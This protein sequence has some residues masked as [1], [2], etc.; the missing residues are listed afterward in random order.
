MVGSGYFPL[1]AGE[2]RS[3]VLVGPC[4]LL[5]R[6]VV[7]GGGSVEASGAWWRSA[8]GVRP[9]GGCSRSEGGPAAG[10][11]KEPHVCC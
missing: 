7:Q 9:V 4:E 3:L 6:L 8:E 1:K 2:R 5:V 11:R 10:A